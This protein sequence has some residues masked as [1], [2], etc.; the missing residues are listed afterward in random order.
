[1]AHDRIFAC[2]WRV[3]SGNGGIAAVVHDSAIVF[4]GHESVFLRHAPLS[5]IAGIRI[6]AGRTGHSS[7]RYRHAAAVNYEHY[8]DH[9]SAGKTGRRHGYARTCRYVR[10]GDRPDT[11][12]LNC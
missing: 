7:D 2:R 9:L 6:A 10:A 4:V 5:G 11:F 1:M 12:G 8:Y 3:S